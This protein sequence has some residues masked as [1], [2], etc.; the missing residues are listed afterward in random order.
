MRN[1]MKAVMRSQARLTYTE[2]SAL[3]EGKKK[4]QAAS[5]TPPAASASPVSQAACS[6][7]KARRIGI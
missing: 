5:I 7:T 2:V 1:F 4:T 6:T 3:L